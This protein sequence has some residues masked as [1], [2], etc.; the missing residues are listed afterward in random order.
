MKKSERDVLAIFANINNNYE[1]SQE[2]LDI[3]NIEDEKLRES[4]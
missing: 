3:G 1:S 2:Q 4:I